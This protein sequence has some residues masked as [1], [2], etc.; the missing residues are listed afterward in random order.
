MLEWISGGEA[1]LFY[2]LFSTS[3]STRYRGLIGYL[4]DEFPDVS[5]VHLFLEECEGFHEG[6]QT[7]SSNQTFQVSST[8]STPSPLL[9]SLTSHDYDA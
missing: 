3:F 8:L 1:I 7:C 4:G 6:G 5:V 9:G 2:A